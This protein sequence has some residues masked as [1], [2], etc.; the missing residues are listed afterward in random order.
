MDKVLQKMPTTELHSSFTSELHP[1][2]TRL[3]STLVCRR[4]ECYSAP[5]DKS[6]L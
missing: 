5:A 4:V 6:A 1:S 3:E 2:F